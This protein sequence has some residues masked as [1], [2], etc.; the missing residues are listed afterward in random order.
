V[1]GSPDS[2]SS[3]RLVFKTKD[4]AECTI[5]SN[6]IYEVRHPH[7]SSQ[8]AVPKYDA[9]MYFCQICRS[10]HHNQN[11]DG[12][13]LSVVLG[14][15]TLH[16]LWRVEQ[17]RPNYHIDFD[18]IIGGKIHDV[19]ASFIYQYDKLSNPMDIVLACGVNNIPTDDTAA[20]IIF[21]FKSFVNTIKEHSK[22]NQHEKPNRV[23]ISSIL[24]APK[25]CDP[26]LYQNQN[27]LQKVRDVNAWIHSFNESETGEQMNLHKH[28]VHGDPALGPVVHKYEEWKEPSKFR[29][30]HLTDRVK[31]K[32]AADLIQLLENLNRKL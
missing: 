12:R 30:L 7:I 1:F 32:V 17:Y 13:R 18:T 2:Q 15:S 14:S 10:K 8:Q 9:Q 22:K 11:K 3:P 23:V 26:G 19:H 28:G 21:M 16:N 29:K 31:G 24:Y 5:C 20:T 4:C 6:S 25:Y 27:H